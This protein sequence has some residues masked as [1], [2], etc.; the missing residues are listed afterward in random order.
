[1]FTPAKIGLLLRRR[2]GCRYQ[3]AMS[4]HAERELWR[5]FKDDHD[6]TAR[7]ALARQYLPY[8]TRLMRQYQRKLPAHVD[9][10]LLESAANAGLARAI[11][12]FEPERGKKFSV[13]SYQVIRG[14]M[15]D[16]IRDGEPHSRKVIARLKR[17][18]AAAEMLAVAGRPAH[19][20]AVQAM[21]GGAATTPQWRH[22]QLRSLS[23]IMG[24]SQDTGKEFTLGDL[25]AAAATPDDGHDRD[26]KIRTALRGLAFEEQILLYALYWKQATM[27]QIATVLG[28][29]ES[30][31]SQ[32]HAALIERLRERGRERLIENLT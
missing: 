5:R 31:I 22:H 6:L 8:A 32:L 26:E 21:L 1:M 20:A 2:R 27:A 24:K 28:L 7:E 23:Y 4:D 25:L 3:Q 29:S 19:D 30:R 13:F 12:L 14:A 17:E 16:A 11:Q 10:D 18:Q 9:P 15:I